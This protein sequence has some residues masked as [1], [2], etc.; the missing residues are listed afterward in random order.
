MILDACRW[1]LGENIAPRVITPLITRDAKE[2]MLNCLTSKESDVWLA[3]GDAWRVPEEDWPHPSPQPYYPVFFDGFTPYGPPDARLS[4]GPVGGGIPPPAPPPSGP[5]LP[6]GFNNHQSH[7]S[8][9]RSSGA[10]SYHGGSVG[11]LAAEVD[12]LSLEK[13]RLLMERERMTERER[14]L[15]DEE[16]RIQVCS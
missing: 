1:G 11:N 14:R 7:Q 8:H 16:R 10:R 15:L 5:P 12:K 6:A 9:H 4:V 2:L 3:L 13:E